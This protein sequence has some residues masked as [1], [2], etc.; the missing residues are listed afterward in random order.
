MKCLSIFL[1]DVTHREGELL[2]KFLY[3]LVYNNLYY[4][5]I[6]LYHSINKFKIFI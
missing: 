3:V 5:I 1:Y 6:E 4:N 2:Q